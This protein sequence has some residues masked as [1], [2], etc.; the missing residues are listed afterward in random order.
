ML[1]SKGSILTEPSEVQSL[2]NRVPGYA[3]ATRRVANL[4]HHIGPILEKSAF[5]RADAIQVLGEFQA[6]GDD[7]L[8][9]QLAS[10]VRL[11][12]INAKDAMA[13]SLSGRIG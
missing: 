6:I 5:K 10:D 13:Q 9:S 4:Q 7:A 11:A 8:L 3:N 1:A 2:L 12:E